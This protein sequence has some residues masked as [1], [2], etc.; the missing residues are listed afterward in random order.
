MNWQI[1]IQAEAT[2]EFR[3]KL[4]HPERIRNRSHA[5]KRKQTM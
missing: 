4:D 3:M 1:D 5:E 2:N